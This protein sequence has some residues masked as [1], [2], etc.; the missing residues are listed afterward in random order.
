MRT[1]DVVD[2][3]EGSDEEDIPTDDTFHTNRY[4]LLMC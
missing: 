3:K 2:D 4:F 1:N